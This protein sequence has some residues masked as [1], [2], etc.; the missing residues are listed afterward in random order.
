MTD[1]NQGQG[2]SNFK[3]DPIKRRKVRPERG[4]RLERR[5]RPSL[6]EEIA[7]LDQDLLQLLLKRYKLA[8]KIRKNGRMSVSDEKFLREKWQTEVGKL[9][10]DPELSNRFFALLQEISFLPNSNFGRKL[11]TANTA[12]GA[13]NFNPVKEPVD[14]RLTMPADT[15]DACSWAYLAAAAGLPLKLEHGPDNAPMRDCMNAFTRMGAQI[16]RDKGNLEILADSA[17]GSP[18]KLLFAG[19]SEFNFF[20]YLAHYLGKAS[21][22]KITGEKRLRLKDYSALRHFLPLMGARMVHEV[23]KSDSLPARFECS[24]ILPDSV[25][26]SADLPHNF[27]VALLLAIPFY[28]RPLSIDFSQYPQ[29]EKVFA[30][31]LSLLE[32]CGAIFTLDG[33]VIRIN[34]SQIH[35]PH[36]VPIAMN[37]PLAAFLALLPLAAGGKAL[38]QGNWPDWPE[39]KDLLEIFQVQKVDWSTAGMGLVVESKET[40][41]NFRA[42]PEDLSQSLVHWQKIL[43]ITMASCAALHKGEASLI[44]ELRDWELVQ[45]FLR[46]CGLGLAE[47]NKLY[48]LP[49][50]PRQFIWNG[51]E[52]EWALALAVCA[53]VSP[54]KIPAQLG[55]PAIIAEIW[56][57]FWTW[58]NN[59]INGIKEKEDQSAP[60]E[61]G[62]ERRRIRTTAEAS[63]P[64]LKEE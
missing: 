9:S 20:L 58:Y 34:P 35:I 41:V 1:F 24:G 56:I 59:L 18:D 62:K 55:N 3:R 28:Q 21:R 12:Q 25:S 46:A 45:D 5:D 16:K 47:D 27:L 26:A 13:F 54:N 40:F 23:P 30:R 7:T 57:P 33:A 37:V 61:N 29:K 64:E 8:E 42:L 60:Q 51:P 4:D 32:A 43:L 10:R 14:F 2:N 31:S 38:L 22:V 48:I 52:P 6:R 49:D 63:L 53:C 50:A 44:P 39:C 17:L 11:N 36:K 15:Q 19:D